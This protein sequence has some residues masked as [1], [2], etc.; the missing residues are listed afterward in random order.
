[1][2]NPIDQAVCFRQNHPRNC[3]KIQCFLC[4]TG[5]DVPAALAT[6]GQSVLGAEGPAR[7]VGQ[8]PSSDPEVGSTLSAP[9]L[10]FCRG[11]RMSFSWQPST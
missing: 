1:M 11:Y 2:S 3:R 10:Q 6:V 8:D 5:A 9:L 7:A 4:I